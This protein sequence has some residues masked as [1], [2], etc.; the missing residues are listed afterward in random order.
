MM[1]K[2]KVWVMRKRKKKEQI[3]VDAGLRIVEVEVDDMLDRFVDIVDN[4]KLQPLQLLQQPV[5]ILADARSSMVFLVHLKSQ[6]W[7]VGQVRRADTC[8]FMLHH[9]LGMF[10]QRTSGLESDLVAHGDQVAQVCI[11]VRQSGL[12]VGV[13]CTLI[14]VVRVRQKTSAANVRFAYAARSSEI[15]GCWR[16]AG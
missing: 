12:H 2:K 9:H 7:N 14:N 15:D 3:V 13:R 6:A 8:C 5:K 16:E 1:K 4:C 11:S 10:L